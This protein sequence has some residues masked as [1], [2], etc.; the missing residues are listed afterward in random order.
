MIKNNASELIA[1]DVDWDS[2]GSVERKGA[3]EKRNALRNAVSGV[4]R[5]GA[6]VGAGAGPA[7]ESD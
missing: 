3:R 7:D 1:S 4:G 6:G 2:S 5:S